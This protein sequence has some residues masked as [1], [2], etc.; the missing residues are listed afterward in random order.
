MFAVIQTLVPKRMRATSIALIYLFANL[1]G[2]GLGP[3]AVGV[4]SDALRPLLGEGKRSC[5]PSLALS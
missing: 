3:L 5:E 2:M 4:L 1:I